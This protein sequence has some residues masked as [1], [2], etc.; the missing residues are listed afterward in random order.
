MPIQLQL[1]PDVIGR[2]TSIPFY[3]SQRDML[4]LVMG[5]EMIN[6]S[7]LQL[8][9]MYLHRLC[10]S[11]GIVDKY[12]FID[13]LHIQSTGNKTKDIQSYIQS[14]ICIV[15]KECYLT[16]YLHSEHWQLMIICPRQNCVVFLCSLGNKPKKD[17]RTLVDLAIEA[18]H[19]LEGRHS[20]S[21]KKTTWICPSIFTS[22]DPFTEEEFDDIRKRLAIYLLEVSNK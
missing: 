21:R 14:R 16:P 22:T 5:N 10:T 9:L 12:G 2:H 18:W 15:R 13:P 19:L 8:W 20:G 17:I 6:I 11:K 1:D 3:I 4:D 7:T